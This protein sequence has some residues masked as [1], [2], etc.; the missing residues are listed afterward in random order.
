M[1]KDTFEMLKT[2]GPFNKILGVARFL[3]RLPAKAITYSPPFVAFNF[4]PV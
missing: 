1:L 4:K 3:T 2:P